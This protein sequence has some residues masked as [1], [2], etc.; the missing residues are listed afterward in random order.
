MKFLYLFQ[1]FIM[2]FTLVFT[3]LMAAENVFIEFTDSGM[4]ME[5]AAQRVTPLKFASVLLGQENGFSERRC[6]IAM[7]SMDKMRDTASFVPLP[8]GMDFGKWIQKMQVAD[9][10]NVQMVRINT[11]SGIPCIVF[12]LR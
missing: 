5:R 3:F 6:P 4:V 7:N 12:F 2:V 10:I 9:G 11:S 1:F 8:V